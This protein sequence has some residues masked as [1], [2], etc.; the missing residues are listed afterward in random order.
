MGGRT[1]PA[2]VWP[3]AV[4]ERC[5]IALLAALCGVPGLSG[6]GDGSAP[7]GSTPRPRSTA[8]PSGL[9]DG[10]GANTATTIVDPDADT[11]EFMEFLMFDIQD[12]WDRYFEEAG[13]VYEPT[14]LVIFED[15]VNTGCGQAT[16]AVGPFY[17]PAPG[18][19]KVYVDLDFYNELTRRFGAPGDFAQAY[20]IAHEVGHHIQSITGISDAVRSAQQRR[21]PATATSTR[22]ARSSRPTAWPGCGPTRPTSG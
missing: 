14:T 8:H 18:D 12:T 10:G 2:V 3:S 15:V 17:C 4:A 5:I 21:T 9:D 13:Q 20:V 7:S 16:S 11:V 22:S 1:S 6:G 19:N